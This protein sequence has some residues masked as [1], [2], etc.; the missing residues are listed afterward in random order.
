MTRWKLFGQWLGPI[1]FFV[2]YYFQPLARFFASA[3][4][5]VM[6]SQV[7][8]V[9]AWMLIWWIS[10][11][12]PLAVTAL[13]PMLLFPPLRV[14]TPNETAVHYGN[15]IV[16]LFFG[17]FVL[18]LGLERYRLHLRIALLI[19][20][21]TGL[22]PRRLVLGFML[23]TAVL[24]MWISNTATAVM[25][26]P[27]ALSVLELLQE[28]LDQREGHRF[29]VALLLGIAFAA[30][31]GGM[32]TLIGTPPNIVF[33][34]M[35]QERLNFP[36]SFGRWMLIGTPVAVILFAITYVVLVFLLFPLTARPMLHAQK[37]ID[38]QRA[39]LGA[40]KFGDGM[41]LGVF[42][43]TAGLWI[44]KDTLLWIWP[45][46]GLT[47]TLIA[48]LAVV[49][50]FV[51]PADR[52]YRQTLLTWDVTSRLPWGI[53]LLF[54]GGLCL[55][56]ALSRSGV[57]D[58]LARAMPETWPYWLV[59]LFL[60]GLA[61]LLTEVMSN[62][63]LVGVFLPVLIGIATALDVHP[64]YLTIPATLASSCA[65]MLP[66]ATPPNAIVFGSGKITVGE[67]F[68][69]GVVMNFP[70]LIVTLVLTQ[71]L[72]PWVFGV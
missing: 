16:Y 24:S 54:G 69:A 3:E 4:E 72:I 9:A 64:L 71:S 17:G 21:W 55:A 5:G 63:A 41:M 14:M 1:L 50:L 66:M 42:A 68:L 15:S 38:E 6:A 27:M 25:M 62:V 57:I 47:D 33:A 30:N 40:M 2:L 56:E 12:V 45:G 20:R 65:F 19:I 52:N 10:E 60:V 26:L 67:M 13:L 31:I 53:L 35:M 32:A 36:I 46:V 48:L 44:G 22:S 37:L 59:L 43:L 51:L 39:N 23:S 11:A 49:L 34:G 8:A 29:A 70:A 18:A 58:A 61:L 28:R 7:L